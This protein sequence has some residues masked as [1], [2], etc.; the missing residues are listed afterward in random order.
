MKQVVLLFSTAIL[1]IA[2]ASAKESVVL[3][4]DFAI[5]KRLT[6]E[7][8]LKVDELENRLRQNECPCDLSK[9]GNIY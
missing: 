9:L 8:Q 5:E 7:L 3:I 2:F 1:G 6:L 4:E